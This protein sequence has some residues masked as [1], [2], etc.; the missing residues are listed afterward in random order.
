MKTTLRVHLTPIRMAFTQKYAEKKTSLY[1]NG[2][3]I[4]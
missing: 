4:N 2:E 1:T 3:N